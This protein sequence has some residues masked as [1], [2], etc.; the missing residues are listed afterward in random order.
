[1]LRKNVKF[2]LGQLQFYI[3]AEIVFGVRFTLN[4]VVAKKLVIFFLG[5][6]TQQMINTKP[7]KELIR[8]SR[9]LE[10][11]DKR[12]RPQTP[13]KNANFDPNTRTKS[14]FRFEPERG[15]VEAVPCPD[16]SVHLES[17]RRKWTLGTGRRV[18]RKNK[19]LSTLFS[20]PS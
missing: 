16:S 18:Q 17:G 13:D 10:I 12:R 8:H 4:W 19:V 11:T 2:H 1:M 3:F 20:W 7:F 9:N 15:G 6:K 5:E 14:T